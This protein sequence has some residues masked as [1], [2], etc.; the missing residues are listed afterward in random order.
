MTQN[1]PPPPPAVV[2][3]TPLPDL[4]TADIIWRRLFWI[5]LVAIIAGAAATY[6]GRVLPS[7]YSSSAV[8]G[9]RMQQT[10]GVPNETLLAANQLASQYA[11]LATAN[12]V[13][14]AAAKDL[15]MS[16][17]VLSQAIS[18]GTVSQLNL[19]R[20]SSTADSPAEAQRRAN[21]VSRALADFLIR[22]NK[23]QADAFI[24]QANPTLRQV[25]RQIAQLQTAVTKGQKDLVQALTADQRTIIAGILS[26]QQAMLTA[27]T[28]QRSQVQSRLAEDAALGRPAIAIVEAAGAGSRTQPPAYVYGAAGALA[29]AVVIT[30]LFILA[31]ARRRA[32]HLRASRVAPDSA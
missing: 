32:R 1:T 13:I 2:P 26:G 12:S 7:S 19:I 24:R 16:S 17:G 21:A 30:Q 8:I 6:G 20:V 10:A 4:T 28:S 5:V 29:G 14:A 3:A 27:L 25:N 22:S 23:R 31:N 18:A 11:Q 15:K 9:V